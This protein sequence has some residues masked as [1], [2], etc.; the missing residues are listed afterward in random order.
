MPLW[1]H[2]DDAADAAQLLWRHWVSA[3]IRNRISEELPSPEHAEALFVW[4]AAAH[5]LGKATPA[6]ASGSPALAAELKA[7]GLDI[8][9]LAATER[10][11]LRHEVASGAILNAW[12]DH[13]TNMPRR[14]RRQLTGIVAGH[15]GEYPPAYFV[16][17]APTRQSML[18]GRDT[19]RQAQAVLADRVAQ[20]AGVSSNWLNWEDLRLSQP[21]Q[22][23]LTGLVI[24]AD[25]IASDI[26]L[27]PLTDFGVVPEV[28]PVSDG[29]SQ[30]GI[31]AW[32]KLNFVPQWQPIRHHVGVEELFQSRFEGHQPR[33][34]QRLC[35]EVAASL[36]A[37]GLI[38]VEA[39]MGEGKTE[40]AMIA[41]EELAARFGLSGCY[42][43][44]PTQATSNAMFGR[45]L[46]W[47]EVLPD[48]GGQGVQTVSLVHSKAFLNDEYRSLPSTSENVIVSQTPQENGTY[49]AGVH[50]WFKGRKKAILANFVAG[51]ID[52]VLMAA[53]VSRHFM[54]RHVGLGS[55][56]VIIDEVHAADEYMYEFLVMSLHWLAAM[57]VPVVVLSATLPPQ[58]RVALY[59]AYESGRKG[60]GV[61]EAQGVPELDKEL[62][63]PVIISSGEAGP[64]ITEVQGVSR[65]QSVFV[66]QLDDAPQTLVEL[67]SR[68]LRNGGNAV[69]IRNTVKRAQ[70]TARLLSKHFG[71][72]AVSV[73]HAQFLAVDRVVNDEQILNLFGSRGAS[74]P[75]GPHIVV[76]TQ[77]VE[78]S[79]DVDF[80]VMV[81][82]LAP[83]DLI[84]QRMG[85]LH[86]HE[87]LERPIKRPECFIT[88]VDW[89]DSIP[90]PINESKIIYGAWTLY[91]SLCVLKP[92]WNNKIQ[93]PGDIPRLVAEAYTQGSVPSGWEAV[94]EEAARSHQARE[95]KRRKEAN[96]FR[97]HDIQAP[98]KD[99]MGLTR[100]SAG[101]VDEDSPEVQG[102]VR[103]G[104]DSL[105]V[106]V[107]QRGSDGQDYLPKW[108]EGGGEALPLRDY[109]LP[110]PLARKLAQC[111]I[112]LPFSLSN[113]RVIDQVID[114]LEENYF[115]GWFRTP[116]LSGQLALVLNED[117]EATVAGF[118]LHYD[119]WLGL[120][121]DSPASGE[122]Q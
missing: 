33:P 47:L 27:F 51:T 28:A 7:Q 116:F 79:L 18:F 104:V 16:Q 37:P 106:V 49:Q 118:H 3:S 39:P 115:P 102:H 63:Y 64:V 35:G 59:Q 26:A 43:A 88:G 70:Q 92:L 5:D 36:E 31:R 122:K 24:M 56:V 12:L 71:R 114:E 105:E 101:R 95:L 89:G 50:E 120:V 100:I 11:L 76:A 29:P 86:R 68:K 55:K 77:V 97:L 69:V 19:W 87:R 46:R 81:T 112:R 8:G 14:S 78:Q 6:F 42:W 22:V 107:V 72:E 73:A 83:I 54:L 84:L 119:R 40:A 111:T 30:R 2:I 62:S 17:Q 44:L 94:V 25:W 98:G 91:R 121:V 34:V 74:R 103:D 1:Q 23:L 52:N 10:S 65:T 67:L 109:E 53:L 45:L 80:D 4:L 96:S 38:I 90:Q 93:L 110:L 58:Q 66:H 15:H 32:A 113:E 13:H 48:Q 60:L 82:D 61:D 57:G 21:V 9:A 20:R 99:V 41:A 75:S 85:R 108:V 117:G